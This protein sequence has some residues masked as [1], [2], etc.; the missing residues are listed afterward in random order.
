MLAPGQQQGGERHRDSH[1]NEHA[2]TCGPVARRGMVAPVE[3]GMIAQ[4]AREAP[5]SRVVIVSL[6]G[7]HSDTHKAKR[8]HSAKAAPAARCASVSIR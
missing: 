2:V 7:D 5:V 3:A 1:Q 6:A 4:R 8:I